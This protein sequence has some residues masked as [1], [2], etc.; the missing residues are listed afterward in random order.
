MP[1][2][3]KGWLAGQRKGGQ[4]PYLENLWLYGM[5]WLGMMWYSMVWY[6]MVEQYCGGSNEASYGI[7]VTEA[8]SWVSCEGG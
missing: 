7:S 4:P 5:L 3:R 1:E 8:R 6:G 2:R